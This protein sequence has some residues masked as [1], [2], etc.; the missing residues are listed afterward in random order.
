MEIIRSVGVC[1]L[2][3]IVNISLTESEFGK[4]FKQLSVDGKRSKVYS[5][6]IKL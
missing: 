4:D 2:W 3:S 6:E 5:T 1:K